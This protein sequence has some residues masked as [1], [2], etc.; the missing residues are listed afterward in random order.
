VK[1]WLFLLLTP[2]LVGCPAAEEQEK[3]AGYDVVRITQSDQTIDCQGKAF[4]KGA[5]TEIQIVTTRKNVPSDIAIRNCTI[6]GSIRIAGLGF[7]GESKGVNASSKKAGHTERA[8]QI[9][10]KRI[11]LENLTITGVD[12]IPVYLSPGA[13]EVT[14]RNSTVEGTSVSVAIY[15]DAESARNTITGNTIK[16]RTGQGRELIALDGSADNR[17]AGN[18]FERVTTGGIY[19]YRNC[20]EG[21]TVRHQSPQRNLIENN[22]FDLGEL[23]PG[24]YGIWLGSRNG[25][26][27]YCED[28]KGYPFGSSKDNRDFANDNIVRGNRFSPSA[29]AVR[30]NG[31]GNQID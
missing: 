12:R 4:N 9:A 7:N 21:G 23:S 22:R 8:Q 11:L 5:L 20:G 24:H 17:I 31:S 1:R 3:L 18:T 30:D 27:N 2:I 19:L 10:P 29:N 14:L 15:L 25:N 13:T 28:D 16:V 6:N 26:R